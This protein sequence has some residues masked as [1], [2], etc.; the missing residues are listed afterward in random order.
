MGR[1]RSAALE[2]EVRKPCL[3]LDG[4]DHV[5][6]GK[7]EWRRA[8]KSAGGSIKFPKRSDRPNK[9]NRI[10]DALDLLHGRSR[11]FLFPLKIL[12]AV[13][14]SPF[15]NHDAPEVNGK[16]GVMPPLPSQL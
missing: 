3:L 14:I 8:L 5:A 1:P 13:L 2:P 4:S 10:W 7:G 6:P 15:E 12:N 11:A 16:S 9:R